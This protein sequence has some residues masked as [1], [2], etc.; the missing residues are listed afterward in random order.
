MTLIDAIQKTCSNC[1][2]GTHG[3]LYRGERKRNGEVEQ[4]LCLRCHLLK[5]ECDAGRPT[6]PKGKKAS[7]FNPKI[8]LRDN[9]LKALYAD[10]LLTPDDAKIWFT[11]HGK[12]LRCQYSHSG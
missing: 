1:V 5:L 12:C 11:P 8:E 7:D 6:I 3:C 9:L 2:S 4:Q 10:G